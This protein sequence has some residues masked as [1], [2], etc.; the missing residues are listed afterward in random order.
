VRA[1]GSDASNAGHDPS[2]RHREPSVHDPTTLVG[3]PD[4]E[5][6]EP[7]PGWLREI[8]LAHRGLHT[9][10]AAPEN[11]LAAFAAA[12]AH[13]YGVELDVMLS[14]DRVPVIS[15][16][17]TL[18]R[19]AGRTER[20]DDLTVAQLAGVTLGD[21]DEH[22]PTLAAALKE[23]TGVP[24][25]VELKQS[26]LRV[27][28]LERAVAPLLDDHPG[29]WCVASFNPASVRWF[30]RNRPGA[31]RVLTAGGIDDAKLPGALKRRLTE[32]RDLPSVAPH[33]VS[34]D[35]D[36][37][38]NEACTA[39]RSR[40]GALVTWTAKDAAGLAKARE[41]ADNVIFEHVRP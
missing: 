18:E 9:E 34:Y 32:L 13:G 15:H 36:S 8:P 19:A 17:A 1:V 6:S 12:A 3:R 26:K 33:A 16:D 10:P 2:I 11:S 7:C 14:R 35:L 39:W 37:L 40:G 31:T 4:L 5:P 38:P 24:V 30:R 20:V 28:D 27:G 41:M 23:L 29:P 21:S 25:M 22:V